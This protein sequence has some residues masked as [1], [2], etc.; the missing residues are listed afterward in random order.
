MQPSLWDRWLDAS[1][2]GG[3]TSLGYRL[4]RKHFQPL[5]RD[6]HGQHIAITGA[7]SGLGKAATAM[8]AERGATVSMLCRNLDAAT[9]V[10]LELAEQYPGARLQVIHCDLAE[11]DSVDDALA[12]LAQSAPLDALINNAGVLNRKR[13]DTA[14][15]LEQSFAINVLGTFRLTLGIAPLLREKGRIVT[16]SSGGMYGAAI[17]LADPQYR[18]RAYNGVQAYAEHKRMQVILTQIWAR[19]WPQRQVNAMH[20]GWAA[21]PGVA[22][23]LPGFNTLMSPL[24]RSPEQGVDTA[25][26]LAVAGDVDASGAFWC[27]RRERPIVRL[28]RTRPDPGEAEQLWNMCLA[29]NSLQGPPFPAT[30]PA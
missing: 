11:P 24:L 12:Q 5:P 29:D 25:V 28:A 13:I 1:L 3:Y 18:S 26:W 30:A 17:H 14:A 23:S 4:R 8:L 21:T 7:N 22:K 2:L 10:K 20:P 6:L 9:N 15:G 27:D 19:L 16:V